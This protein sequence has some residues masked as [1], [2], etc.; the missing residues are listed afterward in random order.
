MFGI[1]E[2]TKLYHISLDIF[3]RVAFHLSALDLAA[4]FATNHSRIRSI[5]ISPHVIEDFTIESLDGNVLHL[6]VELK[7]LKRVCIKTWHANL[8]IE[9]L[10]ANPIEELVIHKGLIRGAGDQ[11]DGPSDAYVPSIPLVEWNPGQY[12]PHFGSMFPKLRR[13]H[14][15]TTPDRLAINMSGPCAIPLQLSKD[16]LL[17]D[18][19]EDWEDFE[20]LDDDE[21][22]SEEYS[23]DVDESEADEEPGQEELDDLNRGLHPFGGQES[24]PVGMDGLNAGSKT[25]MLD[26]I[27]ERHQHVDLSRYDAD[28][29][30]LLKSAHTLTSPIHCYY[31]RRECRAPHEVLFAS[32]PANIESLILTDANSLLPSFSYN[33]LRTRDFGLLP[34]TLTH[35]ELHLPHLE[36]RTQ[37]TAELLSVNKI[38]QYLPL[39]AH[40][41][42]EIPEADLPVGINLD[43]PDAPEYESRLDPKASKIASTSSS[44]SN[45]GAH[46]RSL[47]IPDVAVAT[48]VQLSELPPNLSRL[49][50]PKQ[51]KTRPTNPYIRFI[52]SWRPSPRF[53]NCEPL[54]QEYFG[55]PD[56]CI[57]LEELDIGG[58]GHLRSEILKKFFTPHLKT[59][60]I[61]YWPGEMDHYA[62]DED[63]DFAL[64]LAQHCPKL[65][66]LKVLS[67]RR[68]M[69]IFDWRDLP[70]SLTSLDLHRDITGDF[71]SHLASA[72][73]LLNLRSVAFSELGWAALKSLILIL[74][75]S[76]II[77]SHMA[78]PFGLSDLETLQFGADSEPSFSLQPHHSKAFFDQNLIL[79]HLELFCHGRVRASFSLQCI[80]GL[81]FG[82]LSSVI[83]RVDEECNRLQQD[84]GPVEH[85]SR[86][87]VRV[88]SSAR[89]GDV[90]LIWSDLSFESIFTSPF[91]TTIEI[92]GDHRLTSHQLNLLPD[93]LTRLVIVTSQNLPSELA[94]FALPSSLEY[95]SLKV[96]DKICRFSMVNV[97]GSQPHLRV[98]DVPQCDLRGFGN[99]RTVCPSLNFLNAHIT[100]VDDSEIARVIDGLSEALL[101]GSAVPTGVLVCHL[102]NGSKDL[103]YTS[104][105]LLHLP[106]IRNLTWEST[107]KASLLQYRRLREL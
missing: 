94:L 56:R 72:F 20:G 83:F 105:G 5:L 86:A 97:R 51:K 57:R 66:T 107:D 30:A 81:H 103:E 45:V 71:N 82:S 44:K 79:D 62:E 14:I 54:S 89:R 55:L 96:T 98:Y 38:L 73:F 104:L 95:L 16:I 24:E 11:S 8:F 36:H 34:P 75:E 101:H 91:L 92:H 87:P 99:L 50:F 28:H 65:E 64:F 68:A 69:L 78:I 41:E 93:C 4:L 21:D 90:G 84:L 32:L 15:M 74:P 102:D 59:L 7:S 29:Q 27:I 46:L 88:L 39:L 77:K 63:A 48:F 85:F 25:S 67:G 52:E 49:S 61:P 70:A 6:L 60:T 58:W 37:H 18:D 13:L 22:Y 76:C 19:F 43:N 40:L 23:M 106:A 42:L 3:S 33:S 31:L 2:S 1:Q 35:L 100:C 10:M 9:H 53:D 12:V 80:Q 26:G 47:I 17:S